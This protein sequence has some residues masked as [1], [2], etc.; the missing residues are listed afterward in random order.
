[1]TRFWIAVF[2]LFVGSVGAAFAWPAGTT[3]PAPLGGPHSCDE[4]QYSV[5]AL[6]HGLEVNVIVQFTITAEG[7][8][9]NASVKESSGNAEL[10]NAA[11]AC[12]SQWRYTP[13]TQNGTP[14]AVPWLARVIWHIGS[15]EPYHTIA[16]QA[17]L[18]V[19]S[20]DAGLQ[21]FMQATLHAVIRVTFSKG[22]II[23]ARLLATS[24]NADLDQRAVACLLSLPEYLTALVQDDHDET[25]VLWRPQ[26]SAQH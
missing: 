25:L 11:V 4:N 16:G 18:C 5:T 13:S 21:E 8:V 9:A 14:V 7:S 22:K 3:L 10:D 23:A 12:A 15:V 2:C 1:M 19:V 26:D 20:T 17:A 24:G 6:Q